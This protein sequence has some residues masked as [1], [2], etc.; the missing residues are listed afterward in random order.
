MLKNDRFKRICSVALALLLISMMLVPAFAAEESFRP[1]D[2]DLYL[3]ALNEETSEIVSTYTVGK[4]DFYLVGATK[5][6]IEYGGMQYVV[7]GVTQG[8]AKFEEFLVISGQQVKKGDPIA[9]ISV[10]VDEYSVTNANLTLSKLEESLENYK[11]ATGE[12]L[13]EY[14]EIAKHSSDENEKLT[15]K[16][17][18]D[19][20]LTT[21]N[22][23]VSKREAA[24]SKQM[25]VVV[26]YENLE[27]DQYITSPCSGVIGMIG[28]QKKG[29]NVGANDLFAVIYDIG[30][31]RIVIN[32]GSEYLRYN[33]EVAIAQTQGNETIE[34][35]GRVTTCK[36]PA[37]ANGLVAYN[38]VIE[39]TGDASKLFVNQDV[40][41]R[42][43]YVLMEDVIVIPTDAIRSD[44]TGSFVYLYSDG[45]SIKKYITVAKTGADEAWIASGLNEG[46]LIVIK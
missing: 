28:R 20:L 41:I 39:I 9:R 13:D 40:V 35:A 45:V 11:Q 7:G 22:S 6:E 4:K 38:D 18:Y 36:S 10:T 2:E 8:K 19:R 27:G 16:L 31:I 25:S 26:E 24:I 33:Q 3:E 43:K 37:L 44:K 17:L 29:D 21:Y 46:D 34:V 15:A 42:S 23:E 1:N 14:D 12:L 32:G 5:A 30:D